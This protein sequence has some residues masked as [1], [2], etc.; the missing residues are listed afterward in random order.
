MTNIVTGE[1]IQKI[2]DIYVGN[3]EDFNFNPSIKNDKKKHVP[4][5]FIN[6]YVENPYYIFCYSHLINIFS[7]KIKYFKNKFILITHNSDQN[8]EHNQ[9]INNILVCENLVYWYAQNLLF[10]HPKITLLPIG[11][12]NSMW[13]HGNLKFFNN[14]NNYNNLTKKK[15]IYFNFNIRTNLHKRQHCYNSL[16]NHIEWLEGISP[17]E[18]LHRLKEYKFC[19][20]PEG[21]GVDTHRLW[22]CLYLKVVPIVINSQ[23]TKI[24]LNYGIPL[25][26]LNDW[27]DLL[28]TTL[29]YKDYTFDNEVFNN[30]LNYEKLIQKITT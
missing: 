18:N 23:F 9:Y 26:I 22:E 19:V 12:A 1:K 27:I 2:C 20:C 28:N 14:Y 13:P 21:N 7:L 25:V 24:L 17:T 4:I 3:Y 16:K 29:N 30:L 10:E 11:L 15:L 5:N 8:I 6:D